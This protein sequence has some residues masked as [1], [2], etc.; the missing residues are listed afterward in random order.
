MKLR[1]G[2]WS[3]LRRGHRRRCLVMQNLP[4]W[5]QSQSWDSSWPLSLVLQ[6]VPDAS[7][8]VTSGVQTL[9]RSIVSPH[10]FRESRVRDQ[11]LRSP[12]L[13]HKPTYPHDYDGTSMYQFRQQATPRTSGV[14]QNSSTSS[15]EWPR[16]RLIVMKRCCEVAEQQCLSS[17]DGEAD[18]AANA[19]GGSQALALGDML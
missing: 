10:G 5:Q 17:K 16:D 7:Q 4:P 6:P 1:N 11:C 18:C 2:T 19:T 13:P 12:K 14:H 9:Q 3:A 8:S 15:G